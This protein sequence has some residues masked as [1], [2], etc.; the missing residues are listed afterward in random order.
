MKN[1]K[2]VKR[3]AKMFQQRECNTTQKVWLLIG[4]QQLV[5]NNCMKCLDMNLETPSLFTN[6]T[7]A[8][9]F[10]FPSFQLIIT[11]IC[12]TCVEEKKKKKYNFYCNKITFRT[13]IHLFDTPTFH[14]NTFKFISIALDQILIQCDAYMIYFVITILFVCQNN[15]NR[16]PKIWIQNNTQ[17]ITKIK[18]TINS[19]TQN[20]NVCI[21]IKMIYAFFMKTII[22]FHTRH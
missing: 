4:L 8:K 22:F 15:Q 3:L 2:V 20:V 5:R 17:K 12:S 16:K 13:S 6:L 10:Y 7:L 14:L 18:I 11:N 21:F 19:T 1:Q 9:N